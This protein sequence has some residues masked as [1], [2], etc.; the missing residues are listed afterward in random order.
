MAQAG[1]RSRPESNSSSSGD[2]HQ[3]FLNATATTP[4]REPQQNP[5]GGVNPGE[6]GQVHNVPTNSG[7]IP[8]I[9]AIPDTEQVQE[10]LGILNLGPDIRINQPGM[11]SGYDT[12]YRN[13][14]AGRNSTAHVDDGE[15]HDDYGDDICTICQAGLY[16][17]MEN[18]PVHVID[19]GHIFHYSCL[20]QHLRV[21]LYCP[22]CREAIRECPIC[23][24]SLEDNGI[25][26]VVR[27]LDCG[28]RL[29][30]RCATRWFQDNMRCPQCPDPRPNQ[31][32]AEPAA[33]P[34][35][36]PVG[37][38]AEN[39]MERA[40]GMMAE[41]MRTM[42]LAR[43]QDRHEMRA[44]QMRIEEE[45]ERHRR[46]TLEQNARIEEDNKARRKAEEERTRLMK[47]EQERKKN[48]PTPGFI[49][50][51]NWQ[52][53]KI[54]LQ[55]KVSVNLMMSWSIN[56][57]RI[58]NANE[59]E[60]S[61]F[62]AKEVTDHILLSL[63]P[64]CQPFCQNR[65][66]PNEAF[67][68]IDDFIS[69]VQKVFCGRTTTTQA[70]GV[71][72]K[73]EQGGMELGIFH[74]T[75][76]I[77][78]KL[79]WP[80]HDDVWHL[81]FERFIKGLKQPEIR[82]HLRLTFIPNN[83]PDGRYEGASANPIAW[84]ELLEECEKYKGYLD[85]IEEDE[86]SRRL[87][88]STG[89]LH[90]R[91]SNTET[92]R[93]RDEPMQVDA[94][95]GK[96]NFKNKQ[97]PKYWK[98]KRN[99]HF[100]NYNFRKPRTKPVYSLGPRF[101]KTV[102]FSRE[103]SKKM[104]SG[105]YHPNQNRESLKKPILKESQ[106][107]SKPEG[108]QKR[109]NRIGRE[110]DKKKQQ[111]R[112]N[113]KSNVACFG[114][115]GP[116][117]VA[118]CP[119][120]IR[121]T[122]VVQNKKSKR[123]N[124]K[125]SR[126]GA[127][128]TPTAPQTVAWG[129][130]E[131]FY[132]VAMVDME[133]E[134][135]PIPQLDG[136]L[137]EDDLSDSEDEEP[138][139]ED[140]S[141]S[142]DEEAYATAADSDSE[143]S[144]LSCTSRS[145]R[146]QSS[147][148]LG[149]DLEEWAAQHPEINEADVLE[150]AANFR[151]VA[152]SDEDEFARRHPE[153]DRTLILDR[154]EPNRLEFEREEQGC[155]SFE[156]LMYEH[157]MREHP[158]PLTRA[159]SRENPLRRSGPR[160]LT[161][162]DDEQEEEEREAFLQLVGP[163]LLRRNEILYESRF[164]N[165]MV[166]DEWWYSIRERE[167][168]W[169]DPPY[170]LETVPRKFV[171]G[172]KLH[173]YLYQKRPELVSIRS[174]KYTLYE[175]SVALWDIIKQEQ[176]FDP[177]NT[178]MI[179]AS[180]RMEEAT[181]M[182][183]VHLKDYQDVL[184][185]HLEVDDPYV[186]LQL[187]LPEEKEIQ[188]TLV[189]KH[190]RE[191]LRVGTHQ[192][193]VWEKLRIHQRWDIDYVTTWIPTPLPSNPHFD[194]TGMFTVTAELF[195][196]LNQ[197]KP[198]AKVFY[199]YPEVVNEVNDYLDWKAHMFVDE[200]NPFVCYIKG[201]E[202]EEAFGVQVFCVT[203]TETLV[204]KC[205][206]RVDQKKTSDE[207]SKG[208]KDPNIPVLSKMDKSSRR[209]GQKRLI[210]GIDAE[211]AP[212][213]QIPE[214]LYCTHLLEELK[215]KND[216]LE[217]EVK[218]MQKT[219]L[220]HSLCQ[221]DGNDS[222]EDEVEVNKEKQKVVYRVKEKTT[223]P[224]SRPKS[225][226]LTRKEFDDEKPDFWTW[227][228]IHSQQRRRA[229]KKFGK[230]FENWDQAG[231][232]WLIHH[233][234]GKEFSTKCHSEK[235]ADLFGEYIFNQNRLHDL[236]NY[237]TIFKYAKR[238][239]GKPTRWRIPDPV[240]E[241]RL[242]YFFK[243][244]TGLSKEEALGLL[245]LEVDLGRGRRIHPTEIDLF[246]GEYKTKDFLTVFS[247]AKEVHPCF[248]FGKLN[249]GTSTPQLAEVQDQHETNTTA[250]AE[251]T[252]STSSWSKHDNIPQLDGLEDDTLE[253][254][255]CSL[256]DFFDNN[257]GTSIPNQQNPEDFNLPSYILNTPETSRQCSVESIEEAVQSGSHDVIASA[258]QMA[259][260]E[261]KWIKETP[262]VE[263]QKL[264]KILPKPPPL[265]NSK[266]LT[267][268]RV[269]GLSRQIDKAKLVATCGRCWKQG[270]PE[271]I[272]ATHMRMEHRGHWRYEI[273]LSE[274]G[275]KI[276]FFRDDH[277]TRPF[278]DVRSTTYIYLADLLKARTVKMPRFNKVCPE[279][280]Q[281]S[282]TGIRHWVDLTFLVKEPNDEEICEFCG[283]L[284]KECSLISI[285]E[286]FYV[287]GYH[288]LA[289]KIPIYYQDQCFKN[290]HGRICLDLNQKNSHKLPVQKYPLVTLSQVATRRNQIYACIQHTKTLIP[291]ED[292][293]SFQRRRVEEIVLK[294]MDEIVDSEVR[295]DKERSIP[296]THMIILRDGDL[297][298]QRKQ[299][300]YAL[301]AT[302]PKYHYWRYEPQS[303]TLKR[304]EKQPETWTQEDQEVRTLT[305]LQFKWKDQVNQSREHHNNIM[306]DTGCQQEVKQEFANQL[307]WN[308]L[309]T[310]EFKNIGTSN[311]PMPAWSVKEKG[312]ENTDNS[313]TSSSPLPEWPKN[314]SQPI[315]EPE[316]TEWK[317]MNPTKKFKMTTTNSLNNI[318]TESMRLS[319]TS[320]EFENYYVEENNTACQGWT[321]NNT[322]D[323]MQTQSESNRMVEEYSRKWIEFAKRRHE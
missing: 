19:C 214:Q 198:D 116:H 64:A 213:Y 291:K 16:L 317:S 80:R 254:L 53:L 239:N 235:C 89:S 78:F 123:Q 318:K 297:E 263:Q 37:T 97:P 182:F 304:I 222:E 62:P 71:F 47:E 96:R 66:D 265:Q 67:T 227:A 51:L 105:Y 154:M 216:V 82:N 221:L 282:S 174:N 288:E 312:C 11:D 241:T 259:E 181:N 54:N 230:K 234:C 86:K 208:I 14:G 300:E 287:K 314:Q 215:K 65:F 226:P 17:T 295:R 15:G 164:L 306:T 111:Q 42:E 298:E 26:G 270:P 124:Q 60:L 185:Q 286:L 302:K 23:L 166:Q 93:R 4:F 294:T 104:K 152:P 279:R 61:K 127:I 108:R 224:K 255:V 163:E 280:R 233:R 219:L 196:V 13:P 159:L 114:C 231:D 92:T 184:T 112:Q 149:T 167:R 101:K 202:L 267:G 63:G 24:T 252:P 134:T 289:E 299:M 135:S 21:N 228:Q 205:L 290:I 45:Q 3:Q 177:N 137:S 146:S 180:K 140:I 55:G 242:K 117:Y 194:T 201:D 128:E 77:W 309:R 115:G 186:N 178:M 293:H 248:E 107:R 28:H 150:W 162:R 113:Q 245:A 261:E 305:N 151:D 172:S 126:V 244:R 161:E 176:L 266:L 323:E 160:P 29:H 157:G 313:S 46:V 27:T 251:N 22:N 243:E 75:C 139:T 35:P 145:W 301:T 48:T 200:R 277:Q 316:P 207:S 68:S 109:L 144:V 136:N 292:D 50:K 76:H 94:I 31:G 237:F 120:K 122:G 1:W 308:G 85:Q 32:D 256:D 273:F 34:G 7:P 319:E 10:G 203:Q 281:N 138:E 238:K 311:N 98:V 179:I 12:E 143:L 220:V 212:S 315:S 130:D 191:Q 211:N 170:T 169:H 217:E 49:Q 165:S 30:R 210:Q 257:Q 102:S 147:S 236:A 206:I 52:P 188:D 57:E 106:T 175:V 262:K 9:P 44:A 187:I 189:P 40:M 39:A 33:G 2:D 38:H 258:I 155:Q 278:G 274:D 272:N 129:P 99:N 190:I 88:S 125:S 18:G 79:A 118:E 142:S 218:R 275:D 246:S 250:S 322:G 36:A 25:H 232:L 121:T 321:W 70:E 303:K 148:E 285:M 229:K 132:E 110:N 173:H 103:N 90:W 119:K 72:S 310:L 6:T 158:D 204:Q 141:S 91:R 249:L 8:A 20:S 87:R 209:S 284:D 283:R 260:I 56:T 276:Q 271:V 195:A 240:I 73:L 156:D 59:R 253:D 320:G 247:E 131:D 168:I 81:L 193:Q 83:V 43:A 197:I 223:I 5:Q 269:K 74:S 41:M 192:L 296:F 133:M 95:F 153:W 183:A 171:S 268:V 69:K 84:K 100:E 307:Y 199:T 225:F 264:R 58:F